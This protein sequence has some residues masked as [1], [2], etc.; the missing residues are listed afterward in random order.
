MFIPLI[1]SRSRVFGSL[2]LV[3]VL[4]RHGFSIR[5]TRH[6]QRRPPMPKLHAYLYK[7]NVSPLALSLGCN[8]LVLVCSDTQSKD[9]PSK[10]LCL[11]LLVSPQ[12]VEMHLAH[13]VKT[14][15]VAT[16]AHDL[17]RVTFY[18]TYLATFVPCVTSTFLD[19][20]LICHSEVW[21]ESTHFF[22]SVQM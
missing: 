9:A 3:F 5:S 7:R 11:A 17:Q 16:H 18:A 2:R 14:G 1:K 4:F 22:H 19:L 6:G 8:P 20:P 12:N 13:L 10:K 21:H 15:T